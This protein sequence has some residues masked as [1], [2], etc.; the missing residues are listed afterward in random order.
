MYR[1]QTDAMKAALRVVLGW[2]NAP[3]LRE[4]LDEREEDPGR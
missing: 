3:V 1:P 2:P 4:S